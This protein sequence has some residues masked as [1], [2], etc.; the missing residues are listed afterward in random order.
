MAKE[1]AVDIEKGVPLP[2]NRRY[3]RK[4]PWRLM[5]VGDSFLVPCSQDELELVQCSVTSC[6]AW[7]AKVTGF[8][9]TTSRTCLGLRVWR[10]E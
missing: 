4:Y 3:N 10:V 6:R 5:E 9:F 2:A 1:Y 7:A 8:K